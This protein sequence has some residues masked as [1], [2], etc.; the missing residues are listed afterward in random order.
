MFGARLH[1]HAAM[2][3]IAAA[4]L[5]GDLASQVRADTFTW[6]NAGANW[7]SSASWFDIN[8]S[9]T[10]P[11]G[12]DVAQFNNSTYVG[13]QPTLS[14]PANLGGLWDTGSGSLS[15]NSN[16]LTLNGAAINGGTANT[17]IELDS[18]AGSLT[19][20][21]G[22]T[23]GA[24]QTW[25]DNSTKA[26]K[27]TGPVNVNGFA[28]TT[29]GS[30]ASTYSGVISGGGTLT[31]NGP[32][33]LTLNNKNTF[34]QVG[35]TVAGTVVVNG[36]LVTS[37][38][39]TSYNNGVVGDSNIIVNSGGLILMGTQNAFVG[40]AFL[41]SGA[42]AISI[43]INSGGMIADNAGAN[44]QLAALIMDGGTLAATKPDSEHIPFANWDL[45]SVTTLGDSRTSYIS[46]GTVTLGT[47]PMNSNV[48]VV[49][50]IGTGDKLI[51]S[52]TIS[53]PSSA[54]RNEP[55]TETG[56]GVLI[57]TAS[58]TYT[59]VTLISGGT[60]QLGTGLSSG[61]DGSITQ[62][63][64]ITDN[65]L[66]VAD[67]VGN[68]A[69]INRSQI[70]GSG[71][72]L[73][74]G[75]G[76]L[77]VASLED[78]YTGGTIISSGM[79]ALGG[80]TR[81][82]GSQPLGAGPVTINGGT[83]NLNGFSISAPGI[84]GS[85]GMVIAGSAATTLTLNPT[86]PRT[87]GGSIGG[88]V[89]LTLNSSSAAQ[90][91]SGANTYTGLTTILS[92]TLALGASGTLGSGNTT[93]NPGGVLDTSAYNG[94]GG[95]N[96]TSGVLTV[97]RTDSS[98][99]TDINGSLNLKPNATLSV[100]GAGIAG[101][102]TITG[103]MNLSGG[104]ITYDA[105]DLVA[106]GGTLSLSAATYVVPTAPLTN[107]VYTLFTATNVPANFTNLHPA[108]FFTQ[109]PRQG[110]VF[111]SS[112]GTAVTL[113][114][115]GA[116]GILTW[117]AANSNVWDSGG[118]PNWY[119]TTTQLQ[120][121]FYV[122][123]AATFDDSAGSAAGNVT[124]NGSGVFPGSMTVNNT[125]VSYSFSGGGIGGAGFL[126]KTGPG[127]LTINTSDSYTGGSTLA[128]GLLNLGNSAALGS[129]RFTISGG[130]LDNTS[131][132][133]MALAGNI[134]Q[135][136]SGGF[137]FVGSNPLI[138]GTGAVAMGAATDI[139]VA[140][141][142]LTIGG[143]I[144]GNGHITKDG[145]GTLV[146]AASSNLGS[147]VT[148]NS[149]V[150]NF[151]NHGLGTGGIVL[152][153]GT[154]QYAAGN[155][156]DA[157]SNG[158]TLGGTA[159]VD[160][161]GN[162]VTWQQFSGI[163]GSG[164]LVKIGAGTLNLS[165]TESYSGSTTVN[166]G[167]LTLSGYQYGSGNNYST[168]WGTLPGPLNINSGGIVNLSNQ[169]V[170]GVQTSQRTPIINISGGTLSGSAIAWGTDITLAAGTINASLVLGAGATVNVTGTNGTSV[171]T[172][173][174]FVGDS[175]DLTFNV[176]R[177]SGASDLIVAGGISYT[178]P[179]SALDADPVS[180]NTVFRSQPSLGWETGGVV[181]NGNGI[182]V[183]GGNSYY[184][185]NTAINGGTL[186]V[187]MG[188][189]AAA[190]PVYEQ[191]ELGTFGPTAL[192]PSGS[193]SI[194]DNATLAFSSTDSLI[195][196]IHFSALPI[197][198][199]GSIVQL[200]PGNLTLNAANTYSGGTI[201]N[202]GSLTVGNSL[203]L[204]SGL[205][206]V[207]TGVV[208]LKGFGV[209]LPGLAGSG[210]TVTSIAP[211]TL[212]LAPTAATNYFGNITGAVAVT[213][214]A[215]G[216]AQTLSGANSYSGQTTIVSGGTLALGAGGTLGSGNTVINAGGV[217]DTTAYGGSGY[218][219][220]SGVL[221]AG[222]TAAFATDVNG[223]LNVVAATVSPAGTGMV[224]TMSVSGG[225]GLSGG[226]IA[227]D[228]GDQ[229]A[230]QGGLSLSGSDYVV[231]NSPLPSG[232]YTLFT[233]GSLTGSTSSLGVTG[234]FGNSARQTY[235]FAASGG[236]AVTLTVTGTV[237]NLTWTGGTNG[238][239][240]NQVS[241]SWFNTSSGSVD[242]FYAGDLVTFN[243]TAGTANNA[244]IS[245]SVQPATLVISN[246]AVNFTFS[247]S[248]SIVGGAT[249]V[250]NGPGGLTISTSNAYTGGTLLNGGVVNANAAQA[251]GSGAVILSAGTLNA[252]AAQALNGSLVTLNAGQLNF[253][254]SA[255][256][257][258]TP[259]A[260]YGGALDNTSGSAMTLSGTA[261]QS[262][263]GNFTFLGSNPLNLGAG[264]VTLGSNVLVTVANS[265][266]TVSSVISGTNGLALNGPGTLTLAGS[267]T[268]T[269]GTGLISGV[270][271]FA[272]G[273]LSSGSVALGG[274]T[275]QYAGGNT[276][277]ISSRLLLPSGT[278]TIDT[279]GNNVTFAS[280]FGGGGSGGLVK[281]GS[282]TLVL[283]ATNTFSGNTTINGGALQLNVQGYGGSPGALM[284]PI[285]TVNQG[286]TLA[287][288][289]VD[290]LAYIPGVAALT[291]NG[292]TVTNI[293]AGSRVTFEN[294]ITMTGGLVTGSGTGDLNGVYSFNTPTSFNAI[295]ATSDASGNPA[296][297]SVRAIALSTAGSVTFNVTRGP[298]TP[299]AD[300]I[301]NAAINEY[302]GF[303][304]NG[305]NQIGNGILLLTASN[306]Y[307]GVTTIGGGTLQLGTGQ[308]SQDGS[309]NKTSGV[310]N[311]AA[312]IFNLAGSQTAPYPISGSGSLTK[313]GSGFLA[314]TGNSSYTGGTNITSGMLQL[315]SNSALGGSGAGPLTV[316]SGTLDLNGFNAAAQALSGNSGTI[317]SAATA[318][319]TVAPLAAANFSGTIRGA[320]ALT[321]NA[322]GATQALSGAN[323]YSGLTT[324]T[325]GT[326]ALDAS[327]TLG[328]G[329]LVMNPGS[330][331]DV[332]AY[333]GSGYSVTSGTITAGRTSSLATDINGTLNVQ[334][335]IL[336]PAGAGTAGT[337]NVNG[338]L[339]LGSGTLAYD[340]GDLIA[341]NGALSISGSGYVVPSSVLASGVYTLF[342]A[343]TVPGSASNL[344]IAGLY[345]ES[346]R[347]GFTFSSS[348]GKVT[349]TVTGNI[350]N[351]TWT[352]GNNNTWD[353]QI[354][355]S[356]F[357]AT[358][359]SADGFYLGD[360][361][362]FDDTAGSAGSVTINGPVQPGSLTVSNSTLDYTFNGGSIVGITG[363]VKNGAAALTLNGSNAYTGG[364][365]INGGI[366][367]ANAVQ[368][369]GSGSL[370]INGG[371]LNANAAQSPT[372]VTLANGQI[373]L[374][375]S[376]A[377]G[378]AP[379]TIVN[380]TLDNTS[381]S[382]MTLGGNSPQN[383]NGSVTFLG[384]NPL[385]LGAGPVVLGANVQMT[386]AN[387]SLTVSGVISGSNGLTMNGP[388]TLTLVATNTYSGGT[389]LNS[390]V[391][392]FAA[393]GLGS[394]T[395]ALSGGTLQYATG[396]TQDISSRLLLPSGTATLDTQ[397]NAV[398]FA[399]SVGGASGSLVKIGAGS[400]ALNAGNSYT[401]GTTVNA[402]TL[403]LGYDSNGAGTISGSLTINPGAT[404]VTAVN[405]A[406]G[407]TGTN[408]VQSI[409]IN[410]G[411]LST[412]AGGENGS[413]TTIN[414]TAGTMSS[415]VN[416]GYFSM[417]D[418]PVFNIT[419]TNASSLISAN[420][421]VGDATNGIVFNVTRGS[422]SADLYIS[423][424][425][426][427]YA[428]GGGITLTGN[429]MMMLTGSNTYNGSTAI[430]G[431][432]L[433]LGSGASGQDGSINS[434]SGVGDYSALV[435]NL[436]GN[437]TARYSIGGNGSLTKLGAGTLNLS[438]SASSYSGGTF[439]SAGVLQLG[440]SAAL[441]TGA[442]A[443]NGGTLDLAGYS[444]TVSS[445]SGAAGIVTNSNSMGVALLTTSQFGATTF[446]GAL[447]N[448]AGHTALTMN[449]NG[450]L[451][452]FGTNNTYSGPTTVS[453]G[454]VLAGAVNS[455]SPN[456]AVTV[457]GGLLDAT[458]GSQTIAGLNVSAGNLNLAVGNLLNVSG[459]ASL[460]GVLTL[461]GSYSGSFIDLL[462]AG[463]L[464][465]QF[466]SSN[467][468]SNYP[469]Y[470]LAYQNNQVD[471]VLAGEPTWASPTGGNWSVASNWSPSVPGGQGATAILGSN[472]LTSGIV[473][474]DAPE[475]VGTLIFANST[476]SY[477]LNGATL[478]LDNTGGTASGS[479]LLVLAGTHSITAPLYLVNGS[480]TVA[481]SNF[482]SLSI[483]G[484]ITDDGGNRSLTLV[485][486]GTG[487]LVLGGNNSYGGG[488]IVDAGTLIVD[489][490]TALPDGS[491][492]TV[493]Q[494]ASSLFAPV[495]ARPAVAAVPE[496]GALALLAVVAMLVA[497][498]PLCRKGLKC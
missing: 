476:A 443:A 473:T 158:L 143:A 112:G 276:Q 479:Q 155:T 303:S 468:S 196:G 222:R 201:V 116:P 447:Q 469:D 332:S 333:G 340:A 80:G 378:G 453:A 493:G 309:I 139:T 125:A 460:G 234:L 8:G 150:L 245:G 231:P 319:L 312:M 146:L 184:Y 247:G 227:Y 330:V 1:A 208:N 300:L 235:T 416:N 314:L 171:I 478:T 228:P 123:D 266:L 127:A 124:I 385:N 253:G 265:N 268:Y 60:L 33:A 12:S 271:S 98:F 22:I 115:S 225:F 217:L 189:A 258:N 456:S 89:G 132:A 131:G 449:G 226:T 170:L 421:T 54:P 417:N 59:G 85:G 34:G 279:N 477:T 287:L 386:V 394:G 320:A 420:L 156:Y 172:T 135:T 428:S 426:L 413:G 55:L 136:F 157:S 318:V 248:G 427:A 140:A 3:A 337:L 2:I 415:S 71:S 27:I 419:G 241:P 483:P 304:G 134:T 15:V 397:G 167:A 288:N 442:L 254:N 495:A 465:G 369:L 197:S 67:P 270:L 285:V 169:Y 438:G 411:V 153:G 82:D 44:N 274:G 434:T 311:L 381:G 461:S 113:T 18:G 284:S 91:L 485:G 450:A 63:R 211:A 243:D 198:G 429:G 72:L 256:L 487:Q 360:L 99:L 106:L 25:L 336:S 73:M 147:G 376:A 117:T 37:A 23:L 299:A 58:E 52:S 370:A 152:N 64:T 242:T 497:V 114:V 191:L 448:G 233:A 160:T 88:A 51:I 452:L 138:T 441:G 111:G 179:F 282:G 466:A 432:T 323:S 5:S 221:T 236:T 410:G 159:T 294:P 262:W 391:L 9:L 16:T 41:T 251:F 224:G 388:G 357:N 364:T 77:T 321:V 375:T 454:A 372:L 403:S 39:A 494:G 462:S 182:I 412:A 65:S 451:T 78:N 463:T 297:I 307:N 70:T 280:S 273:G 28:L 482:S 239:W 409:N 486:D 30:G 76:T 458:A 472:L 424:R 141:S 430:N 272:A 213:V 491:S 459:P 384:S 137:T 255:A 308:S 118:T 389:A 327:G 464:S 26:F 11:G 401:G 481:T 444:V 366:V 475:T 45:T 392:S 289:V 396:N 455:L 467:I 29:A 32:G 93:I 260:I 257:G 425:L 17:G 195:Q 250:K 445:F 192:G 126:V 133:P 101:E 40:T 174:L 129:G 361:A 317:T 61:Q 324:L 181:W 291:I 374:G 6:T 398:I 418:S 38:T 408:W 267:N 79:L 377:L 103:S 151:A 109:S 322:P 457:N 484:N 229:I 19:I 325:A 342:T 148:L 102:A 335:F 496:P 121:Y 498:G 402:G 423:G 353:N 68:I 50:N 380:G 301:I 47:M 219:F 215:S 130:S 186:Q 119:N 212:T 218:N 492:L 246:T 371:T 57:L 56:N 406:L 302:S 349:L 48:P 105:G 474:L 275:L 238:T 178:D 100:A 437:Q 269:G 166:G 313:N 422:A 292:G 107:G 395:V 293:T 440:N 232:V 348:S 368:A 95:Y 296:T 290:A 46:G 200:G 175:T 165:A 110:F 203:A 435:Y 188:G 42:R 277:D 206:T 176:S 315:G 367:N 84:S 316:N 244:T 470:A 439:V 480:L 298:A 144:S 252:N 471:L 205:L 326:L 162:N 414:M 193:S 69:F 66:I 185:G 21:S 97:G 407:Y 278:A 249:L 405:D 199:S 329:G 237:G 387:S 161:N 328:S 209:A 154:L 81:T 365:A 214:N 177:G 94:S 180:G 142:S 295:N 305:I 310:T 240:D 7:S 190:L 35:S 187:G 488:T 194:T 204:G 390:G 183:L 436:F 383:W 404:V 399:N 230:M 216:A 10:V 14:A 433:Q 168:V 75:G 345:S 490:A 96:Y 350:G 338:G 264:T 223:T 149:G 122:N 355:Q 356:W 363:L 331:F 359:G 128:A 220:T 351:L 400:L 163:F 306:N 341:V 90:T 108:G 120:D 49:F 74:V 446:S 334:N 36:T 339:G 87:Y 43:T 281:I 283:S 83:L 104:T 145:P 13:A 354:S 4:I 164:S 393:G 202:G 24:S 263:N 86:S 20:G 173:A 92:G 207:N 373:N 210:G 379:L 346:P 62:T 352:G 382:A 31:V 358:S 344:T 362:T 261:A 489:S 259:L 53:S 431:G 286:A 347:Q 343:G